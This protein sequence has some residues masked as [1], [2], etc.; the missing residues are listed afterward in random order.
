MESILRNCAFYV[1]GREHVCGCMCVGCAVRKTGKN[2]KT[3]ATRNYAQFRPQQQ[4]SNN[5]AMQKHSLELYFSVF[6]FSA[7]S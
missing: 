6:F 3:A 7:F 4:K 1:C 5:G 2:W